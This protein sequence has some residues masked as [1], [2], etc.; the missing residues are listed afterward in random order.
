MGGG[1]WCWQWLG[2]VI[3]QNWGFHH[4][5]PHDNAYSSVPP[6][7]LPA[8]PGAP[9]ARRC[10]VPRTCAA[11][12]APLTRQGRMRLGCRAPFVG[13]SSTGPPASCSWHCSARWLRPGR[14]CPSAAARRPAH[15]VSTT[16]CTARASTLPASSPW[17]RGRAA[18][19]PSRACSTIC[20]TARASMLPASSPWA[21]GRAARGPPRASSTTCCTARA[22]TLP[23]SSPW[24][25]GRAARGP[26]RA[27]STICCTARASMPPASSPWASGQSWRQS[28]QPR[29]AGPPPPAPPAPTPCSLPPRV[30]P[31]LTPP[32]PGSAWASWARTRPRASAG[33]LQ[34]AF[35]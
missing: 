10:T 21:R 33:G 25:R 26:S 11:T 1:Q 35:P 4:Q 34:G 22:S 12:P 23:A 19:G 30:P 5:R 31:S 3:S 24:A 18:R 2:E 20:C 17:A 14:V 6:R 28:S 7:S 13:A 8:G 9:G 16:C 27:C 29:P 15:A 32:T